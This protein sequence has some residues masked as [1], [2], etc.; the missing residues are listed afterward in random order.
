MKPSL[1]DTL[2]FKMVAI[3]FADEPLRTRPACTDIVLRLRDQFEFDHVAVMEEC[4][5]KFQYD[6]PQAGRYAGAPLGFE[7]PEQHARY[8]RF[9]HDP[10]ARIDPP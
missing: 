1:D 5:Q 9:L 8:V 10:H 3:L 2:A 4:D 6:W 7:S